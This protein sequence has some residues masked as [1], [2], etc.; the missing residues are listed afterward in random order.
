MAGFKKYTRTD[1]IKA[2]KVTNEGG[3]T[4]VTSEGV[5]TAPHGSYVTEYVVDDQIVNGVQDAETFEATWDAKPGKPAKKSAPKS[6]AK[7]EPKSQGDDPVAR[8]KAR[9]AQKRTTPA[10][11]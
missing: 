8:A 9:A 6:P 2:R 7:P 3:E 5:V 11:R 1:S 4:V 10:R